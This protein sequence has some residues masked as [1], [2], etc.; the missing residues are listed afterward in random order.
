MQSGARRGGPC[1][2]RPGLQWWL[3]QIGSDLLVFGATKGIAP[4][5]AERVTAMAKAGQPIALLSAPGDT[6]PVLAALAGVSFA[7]Y[8]PT[9]HDRNL[10]ASLGDAVALSVAG[11][12]ARRC[13]SSAASDTGAAQGLGAGRFT[14]HTASRWPA[15]YAGPTGQHPDPLS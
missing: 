11:V 1:R 14:G 2:R 7:K 10:R 4:A 12:P 3:P 8:L 6:D 15:D 13:R 5:E 9:V